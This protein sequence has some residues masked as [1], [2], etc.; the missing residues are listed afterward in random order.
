MGV[1]LYPAIFERSKS[2]E[3]GVFF[4]DLPG[5]TSGGEN[6][7]SAWLN[8]EQALSLHINGMIDDNDPL[9]EP[10]KLEDIP[11]DPDID[12]VSRAYIKVETSEKK[13]RINIMLDE[14]LIEAIDKVSNN[15]SAFIAKAAQAAL[16][17]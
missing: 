7:F 11:H 13:V 17:A 6:T 8:A 16:M 15:R 2:G 4:P 1:L 10:S 5:C 12:E 9:P 3:F 14:R